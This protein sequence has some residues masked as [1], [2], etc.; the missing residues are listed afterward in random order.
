MTSSMFRLL[1]SGAISPLGNKKWQHNQ[2]STQQG[3]RDLPDKANIFSR[4]HPQQP[5]PPGSENSANACLSEFQAISFLSNFAKN[6]LGMC[7]TFH[8]PWGRPGQRQGKRFT[9]R[10]QPPAGMCRHLTIPDGEVFL[11]II[12]VCGW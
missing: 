2:F 8:T 5:T 3:T 9:V 11:S 1:P 12:H 7:G 10:R 6:I 4:Q